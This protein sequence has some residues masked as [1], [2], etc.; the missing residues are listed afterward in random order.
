[1]VQRKERD[2]SNNTATNVTV[3]AGYDLYTRDSAGDVQRYS[4]GTDSRLQGSAASLEGAD[5]LQEEAVTRLDLSGNNTVGQPF[6]SV[7]YWCGSDRTDG[8]ARSLYQSDDGLLISTSIDLPTGS[9]FSG[10][11]TGSSNNYTDELP[12]L[13]LKGSDGNSFSIDVGKEAIHTQRL[14]ALNSDGTDR[15][16]GYRLYLPLMSR[17][18]APLPMLRYSLFNSMQ[19]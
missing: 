3:H 8:G 10:S 1:M 9:D 19:R 14:T 6:V 18:R 13:F 7:W 16:S 5:L 12:A 2:T 11:A 17:M 4:F 15:T